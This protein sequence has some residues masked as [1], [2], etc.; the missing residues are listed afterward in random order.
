MMCAWVSQEW[1]GS[2]SL[3]WRGL[4]SGPAHSGASVAAARGGRGVAGGESCVFGFFA[5]TSRDPRVAAFLQF[6]TPL[7][8]R[9]RT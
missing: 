1:R 9:R 8:W 4:K 7:P 2:R 3:G 6:I 5:G